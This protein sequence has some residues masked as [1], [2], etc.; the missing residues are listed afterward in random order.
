VQSVAR[1]RVMASS[2]ATEPKKLVVGQGI[3]L[4][5]QITAC[6]KLVVEGTMECSI[7]DCRNIEIA[8]TGFFKGQAEVDYADISGRF[9]GSLTV[10]ERLFVRNSGRIHGK[11]HYSQIEIEAGGEI[12][13]E[14][15]VVPNSR[16]H[17]GDVDHDVEH[18]RAYTNGDA[19]Q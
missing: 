8:E 7:N 1:E 11:I 10:R 4:S 12:S 6:E 2:E 19:G 5:G 15:K 3:V 16:M 9:E 14:V 17:G 18:A 13:G